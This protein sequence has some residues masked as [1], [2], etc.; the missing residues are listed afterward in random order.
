M[1]ARRS[2][3]RS[4]PPRRRR[5]FEIAEH[6]DR[7]AAK[8]LLGDNPTATIV[9]DR[10]AVYLFIDDSQRQLC[11]AHLLRERTRSSEPSTSC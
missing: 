8:A 4:R 7:D 10:Y 11:L 1:P 2:G 6:R 5:C 9:S 3:Y